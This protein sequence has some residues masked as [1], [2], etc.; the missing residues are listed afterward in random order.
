M[1]TNGCA[2][3]KMPVPKGAPL[4]PALGY[5]SGL[6][7][8]QDEEESSGARRQTKIMSFRFAPGAH[9]ALLQ[10]SQAEGISTRS[11]LE[12]RL[13]ALPRVNVVLRRE[14]DGPELRAMLFQVSRAGNNLNQLA[15]KFN[16][17]D[18]AGQLRGSDLHDAKA[19]LLR[20]ADVLQRA[21][22]HAR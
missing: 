14:R 8:A 16:R 1:F 18:L 4:K 19:V 7:L 9:D 6:P 10:H 13:L 3:R 21:L 11:W 2:V 5:A 12:K 20:V 22:D 17:L 15:H